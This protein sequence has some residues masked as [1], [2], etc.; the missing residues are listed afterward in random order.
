VK[1]E[2]SV[3]RAFALA[4]VSVFAV[5]VPGCKLGPINYDAFEKRTIEDNLAAIDSAGSIY[6][7]QL[8]SASTSAASLAAQAFLLTQPGVADVG[9][10]A[11]SSVWA[12]FTSGLL[13]GTGDVR[14]DTTGSFRAGPARTPQVRAQGGGELG[15]FTHY[16]LP[17]NTELP[18]TQRAADAIRDI[19]LRELD[20]DNEEIFKGGEVDL[21]VA[22]GLISAGSGVLFWSGHG[23]LVRR[24]TGNPHD[25]P[26]LELGKTYTRQAMANAAVQQYA[27]YLNPGPGQQRQAAVVHFAG[28]P[29]FYVVVLPEFIRAHGHFDVAETLPN[30]NF[31]K[32]LVYLSCCY[33]AF[34]DYRDPY[35]PLLHAFRE[36]GADV[37]CGW[38]WQVGDDFSCGADTAFLKAMAD[39]CFPQEA[40]WTMGENHDPVERRH[41]H[42]YFMRDSDSMV[43]LRAVCQVE[44]DHE[45]FRPLSTMAY[46]GGSS[47]LTGLLH[48]KGSTDLAANLQLGFPSNS[49]GTF[50]CS[51]TDNA[52]II[53][54]D[55]D[56]GRNYYV[57]KDFV[58]VSGTIKVDR[59]RSDAVTGS[60]SGTLGW[61]DAG[62][63]PQEESPSAT[64][65]LDHGI[66]KYTGKI[67]A[68]ALGIGWPGGEAAMQLIGRAGDAAMAR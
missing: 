23:M 13:A 2:Q 55:V 64:I 25:D 35:P 12:F 16:V 15:A 60:F 34:Q 20:W 46:R 19:F 51:T 48:V 30:Y 26:G 50:D 27:G 14:L 62:R 42:A 49:P 52:S 32:T 66:F 38:N 45:L 59:C 10:S 39:T 29:A 36:A 57:M 43:L 18:A 6:A 33:S 11:D 1:F 8:S 17:N 56:A 65:T 68:S 9:I 21:G 44:K 7:T 61:W 4:A 41:G 37:V 28:N 22:L 5:V 63:N 58:G 40:E 24:D 67:M 31:C 54:M 53:W 3:L 47:G